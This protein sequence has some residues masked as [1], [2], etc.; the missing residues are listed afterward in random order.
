MVVTEK[1]KEKSKLKKW[2]SVQNE[3]LSKKIMKNSNEK[4]LLWK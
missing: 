4:K 3:K 2:G 1:W